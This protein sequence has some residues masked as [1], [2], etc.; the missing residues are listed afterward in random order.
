MQFDLRELKQTW[1]KK[2][3]SLLH[4][5]SLLMPLTP[6]FTLHVNS[7]VVLGNGMGRR[8]ETK[9]KDENKHLNLSTF[10]TY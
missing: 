1:F 10:F 8:K 2:K 6:M 4:I 3:K 9:R 5:I 7:G